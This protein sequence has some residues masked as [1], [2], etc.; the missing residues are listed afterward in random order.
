MENELLLIPAKADV[1]VDAIAK[2]WAAR[3]G[4]VR[5]IG[6][7]WIKPIIEDQKV[8]IYGYDSFCLV[9]AQL[10]D[11]KML[12]PKD[13]LIA[14]LN[15]AYVKRKLQIETIAE[16]SQIQ[17]P[18]FVKSVTPKLFQAQV[19]DTKDKL[20]NV[21]NDISTEEKLI[22]SEPINIEK[23]VRSFILDNE[24]QDLAFYEGNG[25][26]TEAKAFIQTF[27][28]EKEV[29]L[30]KTYVLDIA[31]NEEVGWF[32]IEFNSSWGAGLNSCR[33]ERIIDCIR[34]ASEN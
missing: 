18:K 6:K 1:E 5:R 17:F 32:I 33:A 16:L 9:L 31:Y 12:M 25:D 14:A 29:D 21:I 24:I 2:A 26:L 34:A 20:L 27:L 7:F 28:K 11:I 13:E 30:P 3:K 10:L 15:Y 22:I 8:S 4:Q 19:F 23:E